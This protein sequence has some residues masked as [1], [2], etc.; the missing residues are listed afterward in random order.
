VTNFIAN[1]QT[2]LES[3]KLYCLLTTTN[4]TAAKDQITGVEK[5][6]TDLGNNAFDQ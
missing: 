2:L 3:I 5:G 1:D 4:L 6:S